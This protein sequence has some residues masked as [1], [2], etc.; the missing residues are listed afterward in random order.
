M[1]V[2]SYI[3]RCGYPPFASSSKNQKGLFAK[4]R[5]GKF[6][7]PAAHWS[8]IPEDCKEVIRARA[9]YF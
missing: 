1:G 8:H 2:I 4:I 6:T 3:I 7:F 5:T 9:L